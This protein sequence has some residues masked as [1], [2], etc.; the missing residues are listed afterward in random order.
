MAERVLTVPA[1][2]VRRVIAPAAVGTLGALVAGAIAFLRHRA[3]RPTVPRMSEDWLRTHDR[4]A[5]RYD[6]WRRS[7]W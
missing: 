7:G 1:Y 3:T 4:D 6:D 2:L 5:G